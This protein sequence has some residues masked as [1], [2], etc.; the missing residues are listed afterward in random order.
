MMVLQQ[1]KGCGRTADH[2]DAERRQPSARPRHRL[3]RCS[4]DLNCC[5]R[6]AV[7]PGIHDRPSARP[8]APAGRLTAGAS[9]SSVLLCE[10]G[11]LSSCMG[12]YRPRSSEPEKPS[13]NCVRA[14]TELSVES[15]ERSQSCCGRTKPRCISRRSPIQTSARPGAGSPANTSLRPSSSRP[16]SSKSQSGNKRHRWGDAQRFINETRPDISKT[17]RPCIHP[18]CSIIRVT[19]HESGEHWIEFW[20]DGERI[21]CDHTPECEGGER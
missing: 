18:G 9:L 20:K 5:G 11:A 8:L 15:S 13:D 17:E 3:P 4:T 21:D 1:S 14:L 10:C 16:S 12:H 19:R 7:L 6:T 2:R